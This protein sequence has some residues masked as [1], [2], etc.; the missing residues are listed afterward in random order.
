MRS[1]STA[2]FCKSKTCPSA[3]MLML[4]AQAGSLA[5]S[6]ERQI[7]AHL[8]ACDFCGAETQML[9]HNPPPPARQ[10]KEWEMIPIPPALGRLALDLMAQTARP[11]AIFTELT[12]EREPLTLTDA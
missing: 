7:A 11:F 2:Q 4:Y 5:H 12:F 8:S 1:S 10:A 6:L 9:T 3:E